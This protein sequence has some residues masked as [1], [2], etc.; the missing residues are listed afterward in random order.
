MLKTISKGLEAVAAKR[1]SYLVEIYELLPENRFGG[2]L[3]K[4]SG[5]ATDLLVEKIH[6]AWWAYRVLSLV[7]LDMQGA[8]KGVHSSM[9]ADRLRQWRV[10]GDPVAWIESFCNREKLW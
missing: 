1:L 2:R 6:G 10:P 5:R 9:L 7:S 4:S 3:N 8:F